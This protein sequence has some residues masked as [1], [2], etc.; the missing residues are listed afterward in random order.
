MRIAK[1]TIFIVLNALGLLVVVGLCLN[2]YDILA[3]KLDG[4]R[5]SFRDHATESINLTR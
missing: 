4:R 1:K 5:K 2:A 3:A